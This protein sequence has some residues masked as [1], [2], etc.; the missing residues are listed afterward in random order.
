MRFARPLPLLALT[1]SLTACA[2]AG[3][4]GG[5]DAVA[6][7]E[8]A[9]SQSP[10]S[11]ETNRALGIAYYSAGRYIEARATLETAARLDPQDGVTALYRGM[12]AEKQNDVPAA[13]EAYTRYLE[14]GRTSGVRRQLEARLAA[15]Q[16]QH[17]MEAGRAAAARERELTGTT[18]STGTVAVLNFEYSGPDSS[19]QPLG[20]GLTE[21]ITTDLS[22]SRQLQVVERAR[23][24]ALLNEL[25]LGTTVGVESS[26][27][28]RSGRLLGAGRVIQGGILQTSSDA[29]R[30]DASVVDVPQGQATGTATESDRLEQLFALQK[31]LVLQLFDELGV[32][33]TAAERRVIDQRP[34]GSLMA[35]LAFSRG[36]MAEDA[37]R[38]DEASRF[39]DDAVRIDP[40]FRMAIQRGQEAV[41]VQAGGDVTAA[42]V[43][44]SL[45]GTTEGTV[46]A[47]ATEGVVVASPA[48]TTVT[49][50][51]NINPSQTQNATSGTATTA[52]APSRDPVS[53]GT[54][55]DNPTVRPATVRIVVPIP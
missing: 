3:P 7:L 1:L 24:G 36:L 47:A 33:L 49:T 12:T 15:L 54:G 26:S 11:P 34:T 27:M 30:V 41:K 51:N 45:Q 32:R 18:V 20:R 52:S 4:R 38:F 43:E 5:T 42:S 9:R 40:G 44:T 48:S 23:L 14:F 2:T 55:G 6:Q 53:E 29:L 16:R 8:A 10:R 31:R 35:F 17:L 21:L 25:E 46:A 39:Y 22:R 37:G 28:A 13:R 50:V 19:M